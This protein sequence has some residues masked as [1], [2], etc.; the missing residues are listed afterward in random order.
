MSSKSNYQLRTYSF[1]DQMQPQL[2]C[3][4]AKDN[5]VFDPSEYDAAMFIEIA[6]AMEIHAMIDLA[7]KATRVR[8][9]VV[10]TER[11]FG[12]LEIHHEDQGEVV[13]AGKAILEATGLSESDKAPC[14][15]LTNKVIRGV[16]RDHSIALT[17]LAPGNQVWAGDSVFIMECEPAAY[18]AYICN[19]S[20][21][22]ARTRLN[23]VTTWGATGRMI[24]A[25]PEAEIDAAADAAR[26]AAAEIA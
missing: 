13:C 16:E 4:I 7:L 22:A 10:I 26:A 5:R 8:L 19:Q 21:K 15:L 17:N 20:L 14:V 23:L 11:Q 25:G 6:P 18:M 1:L 9:G 24:L 12:Q 2:A 3:Y